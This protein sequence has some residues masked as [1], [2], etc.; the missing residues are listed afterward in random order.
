M[1]GSLLLHVYNIVWN[2]MGRGTNLIPHI[3]SHR[4]DKEILVLRN[5]NFL[6]IKK[7]TLHEF[8]SNFSTSFKTEG[9]EF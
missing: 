6:L 7:D 3:G 4:K 5:T 9:Q 1:T 2:N 8:R